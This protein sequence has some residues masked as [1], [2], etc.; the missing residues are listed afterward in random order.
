MATADLGPRLNL[1]RKARRR[2]RLRL[3]ALLVGAL[4]AVVGLVWLIFFSSVLSTDRV[5][6]TGTEIASVEQ[7]VELAEVPLGTPLTR[8]P[9]EAIRQRVLSLPA[10]AEVNLHRNWPHTLEIEV[11][12]RELVYQ[13]LSDGNH[14]WVDAEGR[15]FHSTSEPGPSVLARVSSSEQRLLAD[16]AT[17]VAALPETV[18]AQTERLE[19]TSVDHIVVLLVDGSTVVWGN[20]AQSAE[21]GAL[22]PTL[23]AM[24][25]T[26][27][28]V[29]VPSHPAIS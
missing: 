12:E 6:V 15:I 13:R 19:A 24:P 23:L 22:L 26:V 21:K 17:V 7:V 1:R 11:T 25:G 8:L 5:E 2:S 20:S 28:D 3:I 9:A 10:V 16:V 4:A 18:L 14:Q 27:Y 29:S